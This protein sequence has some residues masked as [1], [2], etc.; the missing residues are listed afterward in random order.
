MKWF[1][2]VNRGTIGISLLSVLLA[3]LCGAVIMLLGGYNPISAYAAFF[4]GIFGTPYLFGETVRQIT[5]LI[6]TGLAVAFAFRTGL[7]N[8]GAEGQFMVGQ[9]AAVSVGILFP[10][11]WY[12][13]MPLAILAA[14]VAG[15]LWG[16]VP[17][18]LKARRGVHEV[19]TTIMMNWIGL[20]LV[21]HLIRTYFKA[22]AERSETI[23]DTA[24]LSSAWLSELFGGSRIHLGI[25][26]ALLA[27][28]VIYV[29][30]WKT[31][32]GFELRTVGLNRSG[33][34]YAG[35]NVNK[36]VM[37]SMMISG[38][39]AGIGGASEG[40]GVYGYM[41]LSSSFPGFGY[42]GIAVALIGA[43]TSIGVILGAIL[44][45]GLTFG[46]QN[47]QMA[48]DVPYEV[49]RIIIALIIFFIASSLLVSSFVSRCKKWL[50]IRKGGKR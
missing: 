39:L 1:D 44:F 33:A 36:N 42:D 7:F 50:T 14:A 35:M 25:V 11:P 9:L 10:L 43:N 22:Q 19:V 21:N 41:T 6:F 13:H 20:I 2:R 48:A 17:G 23:R 30:L 40:L 28:I 3:L 34:E 46:A 8:I 5:P 32:K 26:V 31:K 24:S 4:E 49:I 16:L 29:L 45:G 12:L 15:G 27:A 38:A 37:M 47:M 18:Y